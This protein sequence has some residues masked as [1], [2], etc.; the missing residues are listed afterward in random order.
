[1][2]LTLFF[3]FFKI[4]LFAVGGGLA[5][6]P[7]LTELGEK[8]GLFTIEQ[9]MNMLAVS[10]STPGPIGVNMATYVGF[11]ALGVFGGLVTTLGLVAPSIIVIELVSIIM[12]RF[13]NSPA[14]DY[15]FSGLR[16]ASMGLICMSALAVIK[17]SLIQYDLFKGDF[18][19][20]FNFKGIIFALILFLAM[21][22]VDW[23]PVFFVAISA[24]IGIIV[25]F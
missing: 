21:K 3:E 23:H 24:I 12:E 13:K 8:T 15:I 5:T 9:L 17:S 6:L 16:P 14:V 20:I 25:G 22:K 18:L 11:E 10:E 7:F 4:G 1:M 2:I 19:E